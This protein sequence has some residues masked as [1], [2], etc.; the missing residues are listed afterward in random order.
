MS[1]CACLRRML[2]CP[3]QPPSVASHLPGSLCLPWPSRVGA[4]V[5]V[6][7]V[8]FSFTLFPSA[9]PCLS[10]AHRHTCNGFLSDVCNPATRIPR[11]S[12]QKSLAAPRTCVWFELAKEVWDPTES[13]MKGRGSLSRVLPLQV[14]PAAL[15]TSVERVHVCAPVWR[16]LH[17]LHACVTCQA[18]SHAFISFPTNLR[19]PRF[20]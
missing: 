2:G 19:S 9:F 7:S 8:W 17:G 4:S 18:S 6:W 20:Y 14:Q 15:L 11:C 1:E 13:R 16:C 5:C 3:L 10:S 12:F